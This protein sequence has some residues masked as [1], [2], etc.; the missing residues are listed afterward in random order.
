[1][2]YFRVEGSVKNRSRGV[3]NAPRKVAMY[4]CR[5]MC[6]LTLIEI[7]E[8]FNVEKYTAVGMSNIVVKNKIY[9]DRGFKKKDKK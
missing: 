1:M 8:I 4:L 7:K 5:Q 9:V 2:S 6:G 3:W